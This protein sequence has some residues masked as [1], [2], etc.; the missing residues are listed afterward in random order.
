MTRSSTASSAAPTRSRAA[1]PP[2]ASRMW[3]NCRTRW[4]RCWTACAATRCKPLR[5]WWTCCWSL[6]TQRAICWPAIRPAARARPCPPQRCCAESLIWPPGCCPMMR[7]PRLLLLRRRRPPPRRRARGGGGGARKALAPAFAGQARALEIRIGPLERPEQADA[8]R[9]LF[10]DI[11]GLGSIRDLAGAPA[12]ARW[13]AVQTAASN[14][15]L[16]DLLAFHVAK[17]QVQLRD[18]AAAPV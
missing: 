10:R 5:R 6:P 14:E 8:I 1:R 15:E 11:P 18:A 7:R 4:S 3:P 16:L 2:S 17:E 13:F 12:N 9:E